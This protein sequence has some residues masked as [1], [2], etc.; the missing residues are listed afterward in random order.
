[1]PQLDISAL[2]LKVQQT[3]SEIS[4]IRASFDD[5]LAGV[6]QSVTHLTANVDS[7]Y[8]EL[9]GTV[10]NLAN[11]IVRQNAVIAAIQQDFKARMTSLMKA[12]MAPTSP[13]LHLSAPTSDTQW[14]MDSG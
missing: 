4:S 5:Q 9:T 8:T 3:S 11:T 2:E 12:Q 14:M 6:T 7:Q 1:M 10:K 13:L